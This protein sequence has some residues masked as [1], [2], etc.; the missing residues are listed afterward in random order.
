MFSLAAAGIFQRM[1]CKCPTRMDSL[2]RF[3]CVERT[4]KCPGDSGTSSYRTLE[5][6]DSL[7]VI[8]VPLINVRS[9]DV[10]DGYEVFAHGSLKVRR[11]DDGG[12]D[13][14]RD[15]IRVTRSVFLKK[16]IFLSCS[17]I[18]VNSTHR[19]HVS[20]HGLFEIFIK[21]IAQAIASIWSSYIQTSCRP[22][23]FL[24]C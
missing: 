23:L 14:S 18:L 3:W 20:V 15:L 11:I 5:S 24:L 19:K 4:T 1:I 9:T 22:K 7:G 21:F 16:V 8:H 2:T 12:R 17:S 6:W 13:H 10:A